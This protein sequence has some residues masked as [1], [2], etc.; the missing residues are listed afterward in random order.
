MQIVKTDISEI[1][2]LRGNYLASL[3]EFQE[4]YLELMIEGASCYVLVVNE[5]VA[6]Y[7]ITAAENTLIEFYLVDDFLPTCA[8]IF[9]QVIGEASIERVYCKSFDYVLL[10]C[11]LMQS[12]SYRL[13]GTL[14]RDVLDIA[15]DVASGFT[16]RQASESDL[17]LL[18]QQQDGLYETTA[19][20]ERFVR[21]GN[22]L[23]FQKEDELAGCGFLIRVH[24]DWDYHDIG[25][26][27]NPDCRRRSVATHIVAYL[28]EA[29]RKNEWKP[30]CGCAID[31]TASQRT[32]EKNGF[33]S[34]HKLIEFQ[35]GIV[36]SARSI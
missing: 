30:I 6:G 20:L 5:T 29:C 21:H 16:V 28:K 18:L 2:S 12:Y 25:M 31:N 32:L 1:D 8:E 9:N 4:L 17:P 23:L 34:K 22:I 10:T 7:A 13:I 11:C 35:T 36:G 14:F 33:V 24:K 3:P 26:W 15:V 27:V 19:E